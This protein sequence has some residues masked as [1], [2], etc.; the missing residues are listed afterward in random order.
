MKIVHGDGKK[1]KNI[2]VDLYSQYEFDEQIVFWQ[3]EEDE[4]AIW[5]LLLASG[6]LKAEQ[7]EY[8]GMLKKPWYHLT[9]T[10]NE[11]VG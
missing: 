3:L 4:S 2:F 7:V 6:Y 8:R 11:K 1:I 5:S 10:N 9:I